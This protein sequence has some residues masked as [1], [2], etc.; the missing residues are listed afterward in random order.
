MKSHQHLHLQQ[1]VE[2]H[3]HIHVHLLL[4]LPLHLLL[5]SLHYVC[6]HKTAATWSSATTAAALS[7]VA[8]AVKVTRN[9]DKRP[10]LQASKP[11]SLHL[12]LTRFK[13]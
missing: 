13:V 1:L 3:V 5:P 12:E 11:L 7:K 4:P 9:N 6:P 8:H 2:L 10:N